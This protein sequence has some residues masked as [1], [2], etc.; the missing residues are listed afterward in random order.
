MPRL[1][2]I[3]NIRLPTEKAH[4][5]QIM[6]TC[7]AIA[8]KNVQVT[9]VAPKRHN[10]LKD[11]PFDF[12]N[13]SRNFS[14]RKLGCL[15]FI[16][17]PWFKKFT[18]WLESLT[19]FLAMK[20]TFKNNN[21]D[22][23]Y[24][25]DLI[26]ALWLPKI[27]KKV[28]YEIHSL[29]EFPD[30]KYKSAWNNSAGL[31]VISEGIK[32]DLIKYGVDENKIILVRDAADIKK[33]Q[34]QESQN[35]SR[36]RLNLP[37]DKKIVLYTGH[38]YKWKGAD[39][40]AKASKDLSEE[41]YLVGGTRRDIADFQNKYKFKNLHIVG[42]QE[43]KKIPQWL[44]A[45][46]VLVLPNS[47]VEKISSHYTSPMK[48]FEYMAAKKPIVAS[49]LPSLREVLDNDSAVFVNPDD[50]DSLVLG[51]KTILND[52]VLAEK[53]STNAYQRTREFTWD[54]R[55]RKIVDFIFG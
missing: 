45:A 25:R 19:F 7:E 51:I 38:L 52:K 14:I 2:Y 37:L 31:I 8:N 55:A 28:F 20:K 46:D 13:V 44:N 42:W 24:T 30:E 34:A 22:A 12:Y 23:Y 4:G 36:A 21:F 11:D 27:F 40:L 3:A 33:F 26:F 6:K 9:L 10:H 29:P 43:H 32:I 41:V 1:A 15:D 48:L 5:L 16:N 53:I 47:G 17:F 18:F 35:E 54:N 49:D 50:V 39:L